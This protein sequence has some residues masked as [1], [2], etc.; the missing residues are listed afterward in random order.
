MPLTTKEDIMIKVT[1]EDGHVFNYQGS[2][3]DDELWEMITPYKYKDGYELSNGD[4]NP[5]IK[6]TIEYL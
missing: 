1:F 5:G 2:A 3:D 4:F 6:F